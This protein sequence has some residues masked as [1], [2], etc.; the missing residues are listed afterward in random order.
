MEMGE[1]GTFK[2]KLTLKFLGQK[3]QFKYLISSVAK[4]E[5]SSDVQMF[6]SVI[7]IK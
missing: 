1:Y 7:D 4:D 3:N 5:S 6:Q 2:F